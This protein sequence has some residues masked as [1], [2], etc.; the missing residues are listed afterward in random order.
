MKRVIDILALLAALHFLGLGG[1]TAYLY[2]QGML[3]PKKLRAMVEIARE[4]DEEDTGEAATDERG[5]P[6]AGGA[7]ADT[8]VASGGRSNSTVDLEITRREKERIEMELAQQLA[9]V[10]SIM[11]RVTSERESF[12]RERAQA[13]AED[14][15]A[16]AHRQQEGYQTS[17]ELY[18]GLAPKNAVRYMLALEPTE[19][20]RILLR[21]DQRKA[22]KLIEA[23][24]T[25]EQFAKMKAILDEVKEVEPTRTDLTGE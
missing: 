7:V 13:L 21:M 6:D 9:L 14:E 16:A 24:K 15:A 12:K 11:L 5:A 18:N 23:A 2:A 25:P 10:N 3:T 19:A 22:T 4:T 1:L 8:A 20:A 17:V